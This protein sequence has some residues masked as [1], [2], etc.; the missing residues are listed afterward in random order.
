MTENRSDPTTAA[1]VGEARKSDQLGSS[2]TFENTKSA[3]DTQVKPSARSRR[4][5]ARA[6]VKR[7]R[8]R[9]ND[10]GRRAAG[11]D[12]AGDRGGCVPRAIAIASGVPYREVLDALTVAT[13]R[14]VKRF[15]R[16]WVARWIK[17]SRDGRGYDPAQGCYDKI[18]G[19]YLKSI[20]WQY[21][22]VDGRLHLR[23]DELPPGR[24]I[25]RVYRHLVAVI[26]GEIHDTHNSGGS[27]WRPVIGY[28]R[29]A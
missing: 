6:K 17:R 20:G 19:A 15:P 24:L 26:D 12:N 16:S 21:N 2:I 5:R 8:W 25:V 28:W 1:T 29:A 11:Y 3:A 10:G 13:A 7:C 23:T 14:Y 4:K 9:R 18:Y 27:G 22:P